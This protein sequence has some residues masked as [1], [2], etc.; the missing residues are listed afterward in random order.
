MWKREAEEEGGGGGGEGGR[1]K[2]KGV[3]T[4]EAAYRHRSSPARRCVILQWERPFSCQTR[5]PKMLAGAAGGSVGGRGRGQ[6]GAGAGDAPALLHLGRSR[7]EVPAARAGRAARAAS[8]RSAPP[9]TSPASASSWRHSFRVRC[10]LPPPQTQSGPARLP[11]PPPPP[12][13]LRSTRTKFSA[14]ATRP[15]VQRDRR[16][17]PSRP[18]P[19]PS[20]PP[21][22]P[23]AH[24]Y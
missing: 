5:I 13:H 8:R 2:G 11:P 9:S 7:E 19:L 17:P 12:F 3:G 23:P 10:H 6:R 20:P 15:F 16:R 24:F 1:E 4:F 21:L 14:R 18:P 22:L